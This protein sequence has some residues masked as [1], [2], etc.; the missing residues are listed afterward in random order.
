M[1]D[2]VNSPVAKLPGMGLSDAPAAPTTPWEKSEP[3]EPEHT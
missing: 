2:G 3:P 1:V